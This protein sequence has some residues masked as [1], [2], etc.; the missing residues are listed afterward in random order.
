MTTLIGQQIAMKTKVK[1]PTDSKLY[2]WDYRCHFDEASC[3]WRENAGQI[4]L[5]LE[6]YRIVFIGEAQRTVQI[7]PYKPSANKQECYIC[8]TDDCTPDRGFHAIFLS[9]SRL[10]MSILPR[11]RPST[12]KENHESNRPQKSVSQ[13]KNGSETERAAII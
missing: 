1:K 4:Q 5:E 9:I 12:F 3:P 13:E 2:V 6:T 11:Q 10:V 8:G 7:G